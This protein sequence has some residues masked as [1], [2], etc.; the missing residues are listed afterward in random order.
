MTQT[1]E[2]FKKRQKLQYLSEQIKP[3]K[4]QEVVKEE[5]ISLAKQMESQQFDAGVDLDDG[6]AA[7]IFDGEPEE[8]EDIFEGNS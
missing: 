7:A 5:K 1:M 3:G 6:N 2:Q 4:A 8:D